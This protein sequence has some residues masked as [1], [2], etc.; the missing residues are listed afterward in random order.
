MWLMNKQIQKFLIDL[1][2]WAFALPAAYVLR[3]EGQIQNHVTEI[4]AM[5]MMALPIKAMVLMFFRFHLQSWHKISVWDLFRILQGVFV[6][7]A[8]T[9]LA[10]FLLTPTLFIP[11][12]VPFIEAFIAV[13]LLSGVRLSARIHHE[14]SRQRSVN[15]SSRKV[16]RVLIAGAGEAGT[17]LAREVSR[18]PES[19]MTIVGFLDD[20]PSKQREWFMGYSVL[21]GLRDL[22]EVA[23]THTIDK[24]VIAMPTA[25]GNIIRNVVERAQEAGVKYQIMPGLYDLLNG[26]F[27][28]SQLRDVAVPDLLRRKQVELDFEPIS[29]YLNDRMIMVT[30]AGGS[31]GSEIVR[32]ITN[33][34]PKHILLLGRGENSIYE[35][36][37]ECRADYPDI[38]FTTLITDVRDRETLEHH[39]RKYRPEV[40]FHAA[41]HKHVPLME[42]NPEQAILNNIGGTRNLAELALEYDVERF[43]NISSDKSVNPTSVMGASKRVAEYVVEWASLRAKK[44]QSFVSVRF[45]NVLG[46]RGSV[47]PLFKKQI[48]NGGPITI[49]HPEMTRYFMT[50]PE[51]SQLVLQAGGLGG[52]GSVYVLDMG[53][54][55]KIVDLANDLIRLSGY[56]PDEDVKI[57]FSGMRPGE[58]LF[59]ELLT[60]EEG[61][62]A[63]HHSKIFSARSKGR[64]AG[65]FEDLLTDLFDAAS[66]QDSMGILQRL[67]KMIPTASF[68]KLN[69]TKEVNIEVSESESESARPESGNSKN[70]S[71]SNNGRHSKNE[72]HSIMAK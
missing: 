35:M 7:T 57:E 43:V 2:L 6:I 41:A 50:I 14:R 42:S 59:E 39:F 33:F 47:V 46:S 24:V 37:R 13:I 10:V 12:S 29:Q 48:R 9:T 27:K 15:N 18:H 26:K 49:T 34:G 55:V 64:P 17:M 31:I 53:Q 20:S 51:A 21:G 8:I 54:P 11:L 44:E 1:T 28:I 40:I 32:Q 3:L 52:N 60:A 45:G 30:G 69:D 19:G 72:N 68:E 23:G 66:Q 62:D 36:E 63:T 22:S 38:E 61:T 58:K 65:N 71:H 67:Q 5:T 70:G 16:E 25:P 56:K 4:A